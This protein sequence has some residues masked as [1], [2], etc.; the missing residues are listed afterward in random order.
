MLDTVDRGPYMKMLDKQALAL[1]AQIGGSYE[2]A[3]TK[4]Y[5]DPANASIR[6]AA[7]YEHLA[8]SHDVMFGTGLSAIPVAKK[9]PYDPLAKAAE[10]AEHL[11]P[12]HAKLHS[13]AVDHMR[14]HS[15][16]SYQQAY[17]L[18]YSR[19]ENEPLRNAIKAEH[20]R[21]TMAGLDDGELGKAAAPDAV[22]DDLDAGSAEHELHRLTVTRMKNNPGMSYARSFV[23]EYLAPENRSLKSRVT[24]EG[25]LRMQEM[26]PAKPFPAYGNPGDTSGGG[27][28]G[29]TVGRSGA[30]PRGYAGG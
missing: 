20:M 29:H 14:A 15:G 18:L 28:I 1:Q 24:S 26:A 25:I 23:H 30:K 21:A 7:Q 3:F 11:G 9:A 13:L 8:K 5:C 4:V 10:L 27:R 19:M 22:Q 6:D 16:M 17:S 12:S 2:Q